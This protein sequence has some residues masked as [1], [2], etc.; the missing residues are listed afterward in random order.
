MN[1]EVGLEVSCVLVGVVLLLIRFLTLIQL[2]HEE[3]PHLFFWELAI[4]EVRGQFLSC[5]RGCG[6]L[7]LTTFGEF[8]CRV[9]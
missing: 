2:G 1:V 9:S 7:G 6:L 4:Q 5:I 8:A 3:V